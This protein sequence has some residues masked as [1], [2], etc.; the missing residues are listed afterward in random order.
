MGKLASDRIINLK[1]YYTVNENVVLIF[2]L[3][4][5]IRQR[6]GETQNRLKYLYETIFLSMCRLFIYSLETET[7]RI[8]VLISRYDVL[9]TSG[10]CVSGIMEYNMTFLYR[11]I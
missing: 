10:Q 4:G 7:I 6:N 3:L 1:L 2:L 8:L 9:V 11:G 5:Y